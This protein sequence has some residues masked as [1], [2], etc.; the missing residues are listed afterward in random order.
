MTNLERLKLE[1]NNKKYFT[2]TEY[3]VFLDENNLISTEE[4]NKS[5]MQRDLLYTV[6]DVLESLAND[7][8]LMR[9]IETEFT[10]T[11]EAVKFLNDRI[12]RIRQRIENI[13]DSSEEYSSFQL[14]FTRK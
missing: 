13:K 10:T 11:S 6:V 9:K 7:V 14:L 12:E 4:Y 1:L 5:T 2:D 3:A 8:D